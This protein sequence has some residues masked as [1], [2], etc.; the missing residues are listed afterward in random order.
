MNITD[1][2]D[3]GLDRVEI[4][5][6]DE[7]YNKKYWFLGLLKD[8]MLSVIEKTKDN[9]GWHVE[10]YISIS[11][12]LFYKETLEKI[13]V[14]N[15]IKDKRNIQG[16]PVEVVRVSK[17]SHIPKEIACIKCG[18]MV[19]VVPSVIAQRIT[20]KGMSIE[21]YIEEFSCNEC[22]PRK[23]GRNKK[24]RSLEEM[25]NYTVN[26]F[27]SALICKCG[28]SIKIQMSSLIKRAKD[29]GKTVEEFVNGYK[30][31]KCNPTKGRPRTK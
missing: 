13:G 22:V 17:Y 4:E 28:N 25:G 24:V 31:Q 9:N 21:K 27:P 15:K 10:N 8:N 19:E 5:T 23:R 16:A 7:T 18:K 26:T 14:W 3:M 20:S 29:K 30:C 11:P 2:F 6:T 12:L 1:E